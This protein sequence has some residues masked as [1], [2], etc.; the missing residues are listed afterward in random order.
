MDSM[1]NVICI[2]QARQT[3]S[4]LPNKVM[5][6]L[7][8]TGKSIIEHI[9]ERL[10]IVPSIQKTIVAIP[11]NS[12]NDLLADYF[13]SKGIEFYRGSED[14]VLSRFCVGIRKYNPD[15]IIR[16]TSD[17]PLVDVEN[18]DY[19]LSAANEANADYA[20]Y[21]DC[22]IGIGLEICK[23]S[24]LLK[25]D[26]DATQTLEREHVC[27]HLYLNKDKFKCLDVH[28]PFNFGHEIRF[29][30][31]TPEDFE[32]SNLLYKE[33]YKGTPIKNQAIKELFDIKP[34]LASI[35]INIHQKTLGE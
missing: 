6:E 33:L 23:A 7:G 32:L 10:S 3:S 15:Y 18:I 31:D 30:V 16:A 17:N 20:H 21:S 26:A 5:M 19:L 13:T 24:S 25:A 12:G 9:I 14:D 35:N 4:R 28:Y 1:V 34:E 27:P 8:G 11:D 2:I 22:P 29:T